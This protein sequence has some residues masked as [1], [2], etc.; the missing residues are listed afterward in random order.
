MLPTIPPSPS[1]TSLPVRRSAAALDDV[2]AELLGSSKFEIL[3]KLGQG[4]MG[5]VYK[6]KHNFFDE[7]VAIKV[8]TA[9]V[10]ENPDARSRFLREMKAAGK[11]R[12]P[13]I[14]RAIDAE[15]IG[16]LLLLVMEFV[17][18]IALDRLVNQRG[19]LPVDF[20]CGCIVQAAR[21][22]QHAHEKGMVHRDIKPA[23]LMV[24]AKE[25]E[26]K[27]LDFGLVRG[28]RQQGDQNQTQLQAFMGTPE[29]VAPEQAT[30]A[31]NA[32]IRAD[33]YS[34]GCTL[35]FLLAGRPP[36]QKDT[37]LNTIMAQVQ[38]EARPLPEL[39]AEVPAG[40][41]TV[42]AK[43]LAKKPAERYQTPTAVAQCCNR[44]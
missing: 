31:R 7:L 15:Q 39:R 38:D 16:D 17:P 11:L 43:M 9:A 18:G 8:M 19:P 26:V 32:D 5:A 33:I 42:V 35:Y 12:H 21:G 20:A 36:F 4:G 25:K 2:P 22:L 40:L 13:N 14:V 6:A 23:N 3:G 28:P 24:T 34:L 27:L 29:Y 41:W 44:S 10:V 37:I 1:N 30:D